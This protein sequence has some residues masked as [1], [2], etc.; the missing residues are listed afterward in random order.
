MGRV[1]RLVTG[2]DAHGEDRQDPGVVQ[3]VGDLGLIV[4]PLE[5][6]QVQPRREGR[7]FTGTRRFSESCRA[8]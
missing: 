3:P 4:E 8:S 2:P 6:P 5:L 1:I 7:T